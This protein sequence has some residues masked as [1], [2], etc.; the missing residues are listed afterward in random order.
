MISPAQGPLADNTQHSQQTDIHAPGGFRTH[1]P[2]R[3]KPYTAIGTAPTQLKIKSKF[4]TLLIQIRTCFSPAAWT[5]TQTHC[6]EQHTGCAQVSYCAHC[7]YLLTDDVQARS[8]RRQY[9]VTAI[10]AV[11]E[12]A[13]TAVCCGKLMEHT[14]SLQAKRCYSRWYE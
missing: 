14:S 3:P 12:C 4:L 6:S 1:N 10:L 7:S 9:N 11:R 5:L 8:E 13:K 2:S